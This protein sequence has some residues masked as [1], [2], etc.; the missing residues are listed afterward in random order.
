MNDLIDL[1]IKNIFRQKTRT[2]LTIIGIIIGIGAVVALGSISEGISTQIAEELEFM[3]GTI[4]V[5]SK[6]SS[7]MMTGFE[8]SEV[9]EEDVEEFED[10]SGVKEVIPYV[11]RMGQIEIGQ[12]PSMMI[13]GIDPEDIDFFVGRGIELDS[14][15]EIETGDTYQVLI[16]YTY[17]E[18]N[19]L[20]IGDTV[21][22]K[23]N[24][25]EIVG[26]IEESDTDVD[27]SIIVP[28][29]TMMDIYNMDNY[30]SLFITPEDVSKVE[31]VSE[32]LKSSFDDFEFVTSTDLVKQM[33]SIVDMIRFFTVGISS[34]AAVVGGLGVM[35]TMIMAVLERQREIGIMKAVGATKKYVLTQ[36]LI[37]SVIIILIGGLVGILIGG[38]GSY[39]LRFVSGGLAMAVVTIDLVIGG[40]V[41]AV[42][43]GLIGGLYPAWKASKLDPI[44]AIRYE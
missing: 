8:G 2:A 41:F 22:L 21:E 1:A 37:E 18:E 39:S 24:S 29:D 25:F 7:G 42:S 32:D 31:V 16:G 14:G 40:L 11:M 12:G 15:R 10:F 27:N 30:R 35:N 36:I 13:F 20:E 34:I 5:Y 43:L 3:G 38:L 26:I 28:V 19:G 9:T 17:A 44:E 4:M 6:G 23:K 33:A